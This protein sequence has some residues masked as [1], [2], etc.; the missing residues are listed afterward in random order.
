MKAILLTLSMFCALS[1]FAQT[2]TQASVSEL[3]VLTQYVMNQWDAE[4]TLDE[5]LDD[6][7]MSVSTFRY[8]GEI[9]KMIKVYSGD[10]AHG[11]I[12][13]PKSL[14]IVG[15][16]SDGD[17]KIRGQW[18]KYEDIDFSVDEIKEDDAIIHDFF[19]GEMDPFVVGDVC[20]V[21][22]TVGIDKKIALLFDFD[23]IV[24]EIE[25]TEIFNG[26]KAKID[27]NK[28]S[29]IYDRDV[30]E[31]LRDFDDKY[32]YMTTNYDFFEVFDI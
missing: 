15:E 16:M 25:D 32:F 13:L 6:D 19:C 26:R 8:K 17:I 21:N 23:S 28:L 27:M 31:V 10:T 24:N 14:E 22:V 12:Y 2:I 29:K 7:G 5:A 1:A 30:L 4:T 18:I 11:P 9:F 3:N 20:I